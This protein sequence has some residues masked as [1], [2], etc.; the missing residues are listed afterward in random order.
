MEP[1]ELNRIGF[2]ICEKYNLP[3]PIPICE[4]YAPQGVE[5]YLQ[6]KVI[7]DCIYDYG[8]ALIF[9]LENN[10]A[11]YFKLVSYG[12]PY[13]TPDGN[14]TE[15]NSQEL[16]YIAPSDGYN[17]GEWENYFYYLKRK[18]PSAQEAFK[19]LPTK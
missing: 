8:E 3:K 18:Y 6:G 7:K 15:D 9:I 14:L 19:E 16:R 11:L 17:W 5:Q 2:A 10:I 4:G 13:E 1:K 12:T